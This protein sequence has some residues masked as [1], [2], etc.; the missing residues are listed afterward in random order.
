MQYYTYIANSM[1]IFVRIKSSTYPF[2]NY[3]H[4]TE[5]KH[6]H[7]QIDARAFTHNKHPTTLCGRWFHITFG[8][9][10]ALASNQPSMC[11]VHS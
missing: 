1:I 11:D 3:P 8:T 5:H 6:T 7:T 10:S 4:T 9:Y 2:A